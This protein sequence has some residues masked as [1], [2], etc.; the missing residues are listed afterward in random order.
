MP[1]QVTNHVEKKPLLESLVSVVVPDFQP[2]DTV[3]DM[4][5]AL[6][7]GVCSFLQMSVRSSTETVLLQ[8]L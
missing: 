4:E 8:D 3:D 5:C 2:E 1:V 6:N 7:R